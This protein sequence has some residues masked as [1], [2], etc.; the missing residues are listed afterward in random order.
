MLR[1]STARLKSELYET[2]DTRSR[3]ATVTL[4]VGSPDSRYY[5]MLKQRYDPQGKLIDGYDKVGLEKAVL[6]DALF[7]KFAFGKGLGDC[8]RDF[9]RVVQQVALVELEEGVKFPR[10]VPHGH[11]DAALGLGFCVIEVHNCDRLA[12]TARVAAANDAGAIWQKIV[13][14]ACATEQ[15]N[16]AVLERMGVTTK[17]RRPGPANAQTDPE[18]PDLTVVNIDV[19]GGV[20]AS[21]PYERR[22]YT[23]EIWITDGDPRNEEGWYLKQSFSDCTKMDMSGFQSGKEYS[24]RCRIIGRN[25][26]TGSWSHTITL[27]V[28]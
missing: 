18:A 6:D 21:C 23:Y 5:R 16:T 9:A 15:D 24:F 2:T 13:N 12:I 27:M 20:R 1:L 17:P 10:P 3:I 7:F 22:R 14:Y 25:N 19:R 11:G 4:G 8:S 28:T 26:V